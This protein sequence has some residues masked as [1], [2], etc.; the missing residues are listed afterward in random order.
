[1]CAY[2]SLR[3]KRTGWGT[4]LVIVK[5]FIGGNYICVSRLSIFLNTLPSFI[6]CPS[7]PKL[8][9][10]NGH[11]QLSQTLLFQFHPLLATLFPGALLPLFSPLVPVLTPKHAGHV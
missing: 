8:Q 9:D 11:L 7:V 2:Q 1:M 4:K 10:A 6:K 5:I 3:E